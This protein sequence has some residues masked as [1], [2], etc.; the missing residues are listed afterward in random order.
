MDYIGK[1]CPYCRTA[2]ANGDDVVICSECNMPHH[3]ECWIEN[4]ACTTFGCRGT[5]DAGTDT[6]HPC[7]ERAPL[8]PV[9]A[10]GSGGSFSAA[11]TIKT[12]RPS[13]ASDAAIAVKV[14]CTQCGV[15]NLSIYN[16]CF[17]CGSRL[18]KG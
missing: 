17:K 18:Y 13:S 7:L 11:A 9:Q 1:I 14:F 2:F 16:F 10:D 15:E 6:P 5:I 8:P 3:K 12:E 4:Q